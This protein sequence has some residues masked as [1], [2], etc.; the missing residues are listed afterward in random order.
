MKDKNCTPLFGLDDALADELKTVSLESR[1]P[2]GDGHGTTGPE[3][4]VDAA[5]GGALPIQAD[6]AK[7]SGVTTAAQAERNSPK[8]GAGSEPADSHQSDAIEMHQTALVF[9]DDPIARRLAVAW[10]SCRG[11]FESDDDWTSAAGLSYSSDAK[12]LCRALKI[13]GICRENGTTD[14][15]ALQYIAHVVAAPLKGTAKKGS[16]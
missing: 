13:N 12:R 3:T 15:L 9:L 10:A 16:K 11:K 5:H 1:S 14:T 7:S 6:T 8:A 4:P 2:D